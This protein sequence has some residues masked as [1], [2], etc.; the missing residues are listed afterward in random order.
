[1]IDNDVFPRDE[2]GNLLHKKPCQ[3]EG[4]DHPNWHVCLV[5]KPDT[6]PELLKQPK[7]RRGFTMTDE[8]RENISIAN[9]HRWEL[10]NRAR[11]NRMV[12]YYKENNVGYKQVGA[13]FGVSGS[14]AL[15][16][17]KAAEARGE[18]TMRKRGYNVRQAS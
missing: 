15:K 8:H 17:L 5:G 18:L 14:T 12:A 7:H 11:D 2:D 16:A 4:C 9:Q 6:F 10:R 13:H 3:T 1:M